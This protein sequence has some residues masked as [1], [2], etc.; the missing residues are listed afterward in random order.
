[1]WVDGT[2]ISIN[3]VVMRLNSL[4]LGSVC[5]TTIRE[6]CVSESS[7]K[8]RECVMSISTKHG[9]WDYEAYAAIPSDGKR[10][11]II[12]GE[13]S[14]NPA[15]NLYHQEL[16]RHIQFQLYTQ[17]ELKGFGKVINAPVDLQL[18]DHD[19]VQPDLVVV[20]RERN[21]ILTPTKIL[22]IPNLVVEIL[23]ASNLDHDLKTKRKLYESAGIPE[24][25]IVSP[26]NHYVLQLL[27]VDGVYVEQTETECI[28]MKTLPCAV[29]DL[30]RVW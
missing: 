20:M 13:H 18:S 5:L 25:W 29:V 6:Q 3:R 27:L 23:S 4:L 9:H 21:H 17:I 10:H 30:T 1:M 12:G 14:V 7:I 15:P 11:E 8:L 24:C 19:I 28:K 2:R 26:E 22:G 16:S